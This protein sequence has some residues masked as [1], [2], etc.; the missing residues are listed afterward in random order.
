MVKPKNLQDQGF[1]SH[2]MNQYIDYKERFGVNEVITEESSTVQSDYHSKKTSKFQSGQFTDRKID[3]NNVRIPL[4][5][6]RESEER[7]EMVQSPQSAR[8]ILQEVQ[9]K[10]L[11]KLKLKLEFGLNSAHQTPRKDFNQSPRKNQVRSPRVEVNY[12]P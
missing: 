6:I 10:R 4:E 11:N 12:A 3:L 9:E 1:E 2:R 8:T 5:K 7:K